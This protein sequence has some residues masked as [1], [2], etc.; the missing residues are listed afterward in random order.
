MPSGQR[1]L[2]AAEGQPVDLQVY[3]WLQKIAG[4]LNSTNGMVLQIL[5]RAHQCQPRE[6][7]NHAEYD[8][9]HRKCSQVGMV[10]WPQ[11]PWQIL[12]PPRWSHSCPSSTLSQF[13]QQPAKV[14]TG[15]LIPHFN[16]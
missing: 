10:A 5:G 1:K 16:K 9:C 6:I 3:Q 14:K 12:Y 4:I 8:C 15:Q 11:W 7:Q 13:D 2:A